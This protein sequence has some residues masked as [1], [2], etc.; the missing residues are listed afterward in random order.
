MPPRTISFPS[1]GVALLFI[2]S[3]AVMPFAAWAI[4]P[5][6][7]ED[8][9]AAAKAGTPI[10]YPKF[11]RL[12]SPTSPGGLPTVG[13]IDAVVLLIDFPDVP[14]GRPASFFESL[15]FA[16]TGK[17]LRTY[18]IENSYE[19]LTVDG[20]VTSWLRSNLSFRDYYVNRDHLSGTADD[21]GFDISHSAYAPGVDPYPKNVWG[22]VMEAVTLA[23][24][25]I[26]FTRFDN[27]GDGVVDALFIVHSGPGAEEMGANA[28]FIWSHKSNL[29]DYLASI[30]VAPSTVPGGMADGV[31]IGNYVMVPETGKLGVVCHEFGH[32]LGLPDLYR[33][34]RQTG[35]QQSVVGVFDI[36]DNGAWIDNGVTPGHFSAWC[37]YH[38]GWIEPTPVELG[39]S[40][41]PLI[42][43]ARLF[44]AASLT[45]ARG[46]YRVLANPLGPDWSRNRPGNGEYFLL[47][48]RFAGEENFDKLL[49]ASGLAIWHVDESKADNDEA[50]A[51]QHLLTLVQA[52]GEDWTS[53]GR[54]RLGESTDLWPG[55][56]QVANFTHDTNP[57]SAAHGGGFSGAEVRNIRRFGE[58][59]EADLADVIRIGEP[60]AYPNPLVMGRGEDR[61]SFVFRPGGA[62][63]GAAAAAPIRVRVYDLLGNL[64]TTITSEESP[65]FWDCRNA[66]GEMVGSGIYFFVMEAGGETADGKLA[67]IH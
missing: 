15:V 62:G 64:V 50:D 38:L 60:Y 44:S 46:F 11:P 2:L 51:N 52:D 8:V 45:G 48:D 67:I 66:S 7:P 10:S 1:W 43:G 34:D 16:P 54:D 53:M 19:Q 49:P 25:G 4:V 5:L 9:A 36:M 20:E 17:S 14:A 22:I 31:V 42:E 21:Y 47:E 55:S 61:V 39:G 32:M 13:A 18:Y 37:K 29:A 24:P 57:S 33:T 28:N 63:A 26:D 23:D 30:G 40:G 41:A 58:G 6:P 56:L 65:V 12:L 59:I 3:G 35:A 27:D